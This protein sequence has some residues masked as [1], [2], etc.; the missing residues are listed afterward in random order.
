MERRPHPDHDR[1]TM[2][3]VIGLWLLALVAV[4]LFAFEGWGQWAGTVGF[5]AAIGLLVGT[6][7]N[8]CL[9]PSCGE[10]LAREKDSTEFRC[11]TCGIVW[12][13]RCFGDSFWEN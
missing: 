3:R 13:T 7:V 1:Q 8:R 2:R 10:S 5:L 9:C 6:P 11:A 4:L 12:E